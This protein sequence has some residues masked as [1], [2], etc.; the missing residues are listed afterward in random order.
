MRFSSNNKYLA[1]GGGDCILRIWRVL[2]P[3]NSP[4]PM[5]LFSN[6]PFR[7]Y[8]GH[9]RDIVDISWCSANPDMLATAS[10]DK[11]AIIWNVR[12]TKPKQIFS[13]P[14]MVTSISFKPGSDETFATGSFD[15]MAR[16]WSLKHTKVVDWAETPSNITALSY[17]LDGERLVVGTLKGIC[18]VFDTSTQ[19]LMQ[20]STIT[21]KNRRGKFSNGRKVTEIKFTLNR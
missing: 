17:S 21:V 10:H 14:S 12:D 8:V 11:T 4:D 16:V 19:K 7:E 3:E 18:I 9:E 13:M 5:Q 1:T 20:L 15:K 6:K 2:D